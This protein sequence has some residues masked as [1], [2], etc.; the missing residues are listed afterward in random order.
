MQPSC[1]AKNKKISFAITTTLLIT[2]VKF[3]N[4]VKI[5]KKYYDEPVDNFC[6][7]QK[8]GNNDEMKASGV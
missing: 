1:Y 2:Y 7:R 8:E 5:P 6:K 3:T 4:K